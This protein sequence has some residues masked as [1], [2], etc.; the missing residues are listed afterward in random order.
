VIATTLALVEMARQ[1]GRPASETLR[2]E[3]V[4][5]EQSDLRDVPKS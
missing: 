3:T 1:A 4:L 5:E 2:E